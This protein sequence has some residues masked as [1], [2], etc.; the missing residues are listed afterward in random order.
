MGTLNFVFSSFVDLSEKIFDENLESIPYDF[1][2]LKQ[3]IKYLNTNKKPDEKNVIRPLNFIGE[4]SFSRIVFDLKH[5]KSMFFLEQNCG[6]MC[7]IGW[8]V[9]GVK[10]EGTWTLHSVEVMYFS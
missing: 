3:S 5:E 1:T 10:K 9:F 7:K 6:L 2:E 4:I 8:R